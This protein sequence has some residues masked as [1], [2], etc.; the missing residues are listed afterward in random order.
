MKTKVSVNKQVLINAV[1]QAEANGPL[2][3][4]AQLYERAAEIYNSNGNVQKITYS[5]ACLRVKE[6]GIKLKTLSGKK[7][8]GK[9]NA[10]QIAAMRAGRGKRIPKGD[11]FSKS[12]IAKNAIEDLRKHVP[13]RFHNLINSIAKGSRV[14]A[15]K[16]HCLDCCTYQTAEVRRCAATTC[17]KWLFRPYQGK[18]IEE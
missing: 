7:G 3:N 12:E 13:E 9:M 4:K 2:E 11:K 17:P 1:A 18:E 16:L 6:Y 15:F 14:S 10:A 5:V 8:R